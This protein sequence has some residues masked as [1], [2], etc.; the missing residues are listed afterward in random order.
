MIRVAVAAVLIAVF[1]Q[2]AAARPVTD[3]PLRD[4][5]FSIDTPLIDLLVS[6]RASAVV[7]RESPGAFARVPEALSLRSVP[8]FGAI[9]SL[10][11][12][13][14]ILGISRPALDRIGATLRTVPVTA[15]DRTRRCARYDAAAPRFALPAGKPR[16]LLFEK[17]VGARDAAA[18]DA[19]HS[20][21]VDM[22][23]RNGW[24]IVATDRAGALLPAT[25]RQFDLVIWNNVSGDVLTLSERRSFER[26]MTRGGAF[27][28]VHG[29]GGDPIYF[30]DWYADTLLGARFAGH[31]RDPAFR[32]TTVRLDP[33]P[34]RVR[35]ASPDP[36]RCG[37]NGIRSK[38]VRDRPVR[39]S[40]LRSTRD[41]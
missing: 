33:L 15:L 36:G 28:G 27:V 30:W 3:C 35:R 34:V 39:M 20:A 11:A 13:A 38:P 18:I 10:R 31:P 37:R 25:L 16:I 29:S 6:D 7:E 9:F 5:P 4:R 2:P 1:A 17:V 41:I 21:F 14:P 32:E 22:A 40:W 23:R 12:G 8:G 19:A 26:W 24:A